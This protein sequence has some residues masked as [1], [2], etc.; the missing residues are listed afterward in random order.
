MRPA[1]IRWFGSAYLLWM[2]AEIG[3]ECWIMVTFTTSRPFDDDATAFRLV[4]FGLIAAHLLF[5]LG[6]R[7]FIVVR[8]R[9]IARTIFTVLLLI[10]SAFFLYQVG[11]NLLAGRLNPSVSKLG[12]M[13]LSLAAQVALTWLLFRPDATA[14]LR[15]EIDD[16]PELLEETFR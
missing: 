7:H 14:W 10:G 16:A 8:P 15:G 12:F 1:S 13:L 4:L 9:P 11:Q 2:V 6:L 5:N 3:W